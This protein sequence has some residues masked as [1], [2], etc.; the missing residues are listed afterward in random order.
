MIVNAGQLINLNI[1]VTD[2][3]GILVFDDTPKATI[4]SLKNNKYF[5]GL[6]F[7]DEEIAIILPHLGGGLYGFD[8]ML[9]ETDELE[10]IMISDKYNTS[11]SVNII[12]IPKDCVHYSKP[13]EEFI[14]FVPIDN[15]T[16]LLTY[17]LTNSL[18]L[19]YVQDTDSWSEL[20]TQNLLTAVN[21]KIARMGVHLDSGI[22]SISI[23]DLGISKFVF[24]LNVTEESHKGEITIVNSNSLRSLDGSDT[25]L[26][27]EDGS[28]IAGVKIS[29]TDTDTKSVVGTTTTNESGEWHMMIAK[30]KYLFTFEKQG[31]T[32]VSFFREV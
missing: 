6:F 8:F 20:R 24:N 18:G 31:Y 32:P 19:Y 26:L 22:Y 7:S 15:N 23:Y 9:D 30:G 14:Y 2:I 28:P 25:T 17:E 1:E 13:G 27:T 11:K 16:S 21:E 4:K 12:V 10:V 29:A 3:N 5:N